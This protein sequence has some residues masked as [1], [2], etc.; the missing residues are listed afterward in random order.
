MFG[1]GRN[2]PLIFISALFSDLGVPLAA[3]LVSRQVLCLDDQLKTSQA[4]FMIK[5]SYIVRDYVEIYVRNVR[6]VGL[7]TLYVVRVELKTYFSNESFSYYNTEAA[8]RLR[9]ECMT[10][11]QMMLSF[12]ILSD[13]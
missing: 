4:K 9:E 12:H 6:S 5:Y 1:F 8:A 13:D 11:D 3:I 10:R 2:G 7:L